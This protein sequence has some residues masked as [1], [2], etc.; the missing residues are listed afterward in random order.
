VDRGRGDVDTFG[1]LA[2]EVPD[3]LHAQQASA[4]EVTG[5]AHHDRLGPG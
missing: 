2:A 1:D 3:H 5:P 4:A